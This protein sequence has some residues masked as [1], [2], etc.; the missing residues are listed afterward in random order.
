MEEEIVVN[1]G[2]NPGLNARAKLVKIDL[3]ENG[4]IP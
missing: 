3:K 2:N 4:S 1:S